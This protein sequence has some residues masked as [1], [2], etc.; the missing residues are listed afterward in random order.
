M[1][2]GYIP[3]IS[4]IAGNC[5]GGAVYS[6]GITDFIFVID[7]ISQMFVTGPKVIKSVTNEDI[8]AKELGVPMCTHPKAV[9]LIFICLTKRNVSAA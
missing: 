7:E 5:A 8:T 2:S 6:P 9:S 3:Q 4:I 1:A